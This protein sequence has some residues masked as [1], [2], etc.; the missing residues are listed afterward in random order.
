MTHLTK[1]ATELQKIK[2][3]KIYLRPSKSY[4]HE[5]GM[6]EAANKAKVLW[7]ILIPDYLKQLIT[8]LMQITILSKCNLLR[9]VKHTVYQ[10]YINYGN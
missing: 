4:N 5:T 6:R 3:F 8:M 2:K 10:N 7:T 9:F 1:S